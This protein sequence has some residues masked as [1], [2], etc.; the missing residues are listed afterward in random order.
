VVIVILTS[1]GATCGTDVTDWESFDWGNAIVAGTSLNFTAI[2]PTLRLVPNSVTLAPT[3]PN[4]GLATAPTSRQA[5]VGKAGSGHH[6]VPVPEAAIRAST[7]QGRLAVTSDVGMIQA[8]IGF[9]GHTG[10]QKT[11]R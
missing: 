11:V 7:P 8:W 6:Q 5:T 1:P 4:F 2:V 9:F 3:R 10:N